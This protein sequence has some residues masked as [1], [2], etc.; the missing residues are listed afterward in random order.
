VTRRADQ[1]GTELAGIA[2]GSSPIAPQRR[3]QRFSDRAWSGDPLLP[4]LRGLPAT[5]RE[6]LDSAAGGPCGPDGPDAERALTE[7]RQAVRRFVEDNA[8]DWLGHCVAIF[9]CGP[10][11]L[12][13]AIPL[14]AGLGEQAVFGPRPHVRPLLV[15]LQRHPAYRIAVVNRR[16]AWLFAVAGDRI[17]TVP[18]HR[19]QACPARATA[20]GTAWNRTGSAGA[21]PNSRTTTS[22]T[23][24]ISSLRPSAPGRSGS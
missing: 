24:P 23:S 22:T 16:H 11:G 6:L 12:A 4:A 3:D 19:Q 21:S 18:N 13:E 8:R 15:A 5:A 9:I 17:D 2:K 20:A 10:A 14:P 1:L 7:A